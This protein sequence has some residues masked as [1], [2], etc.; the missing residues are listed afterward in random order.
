MLTNHKRIKSILSIVYIHDTMSA[1]N[2]YCFTCRTDSVEDGDK[3]VQT[4]I[5]NF[6]RI[7]E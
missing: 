6:G 7:G 1:S 4:A 2:D 3:I 5:D